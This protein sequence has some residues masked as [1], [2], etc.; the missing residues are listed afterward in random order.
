MNAD[1]PSILIQGIGAMGGVTAARLLQAGYAPTLIAGSRD[2]A[3]EIR[4]AGL[5]LR[6]G[7]Q[8]RS[9]P[10]NVYAHVADV[11]EALQFD[12]VLLITKANDVSNAA[13]E[14]LPRA[15]DATIFVPMQ[16]GIVTE[17]VAEIVGTA[18][19][20]PSLLNWAATMHAPGDYEQTVS[21]S[22]VIGESD[23]VFTARLRALAA[24]LGH[25]VPIKMSDNILGAQWAKL[26]MNCSVTVLGALCGLPHEEW[27]RSDVGRDV[28]VR[29][30][31]EVLAVAAAAGVRLEKL[32]VDPM[33]PLVGRAEEIDRWLEAVLDVYG[34]SRPSILVDL[35][36]G[37]RTEVD[38][39]TGY[40]AE[41]G[42]LL[43]VPTPLCVE[44]T[45]M[46]HEVEAGTRGLTLVNLK[47]LAAV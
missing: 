37:K 45:K 2:R 44:A 29:V 20:I 28:F 5:T 4:N 13:R 42:K 26:Q 43:G 18:R 11:P 39:I 22:M 32:A 8:L 16:N 24:I 30:C 25:V 33:M 3:N 38:F 47:A 19:V 14:A 34:K 40:V 1:T 7:K 31:R 15:H 21:H 35:D 27:I 10:A 23:G 36:R 46:V 41:Q 17:R 12:L 9:F 6:E